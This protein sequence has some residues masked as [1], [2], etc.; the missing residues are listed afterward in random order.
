MP[1]TLIFAA[2]LDYTNLEVYFGYLQM[3]PS[4]DASVDGIKH[5]FHRTKIHLWD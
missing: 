5:I 1:I 2:L 4:H 3:M